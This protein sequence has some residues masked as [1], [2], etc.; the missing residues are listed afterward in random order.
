MPILVDEAQSDFVEKRQ[1]L[2]SALIAN[3]VVWC[4]KKKKSSGVMLKL[5]FQKAYDSVRWTSLTWYLKEWVLE[6]GEDELLVAAQWHQCPSLLT[7]P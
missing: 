7:D 4:I 3:E 6:Y 5:D 2:N 1:I